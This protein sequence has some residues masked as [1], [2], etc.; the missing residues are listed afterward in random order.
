[1]CDITYEQFEFWC[2]HWGMTTEEGFRA[3]CLAANIV[4]QNFVNHF[5]YAIKISNENHSDDFKGIVTKSERN[6]A[7]LKVFYSSLEREV[8]NMLEK[9]NKEQ[10]T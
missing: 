5:E 6:A 8:F 3:M 1:M 4:D 2:K 9:H 7:A 10:I